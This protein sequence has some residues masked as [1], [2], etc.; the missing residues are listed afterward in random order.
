M[1][2][3]SNAG[4]DRILKRS[5]AA[6]AGPNSIFQISGWMGR[7][8]L[9]CAGPKDLQQFFVGLPSSILLFSYHGRHYAQTAVHQASVID[10][11]RPAVGRLRSESPADHCIGIP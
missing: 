2:M 8:C 9:I 10:F 11:N 5:W 7:L 6:Q 3:K 4:P 1:V